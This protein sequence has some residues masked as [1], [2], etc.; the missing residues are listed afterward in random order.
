MDVERNSKTRCVGDEFGCRKHDL[1]VDDIRT[2]NQN[3]GNRDNGNKRNMGLD[4]GKVPEFVVG[5]SD[6]RVFIHRQGE[7]ITTTSSTHKNGSGNDKKNRVVNGCGI[8]HVDF[9]ESNSVDNEN[10]NG[11]DV[12]ND[13]DFAS[14]V[15]IQHS[16]T[17]R[18]PVSLKV[19][20]SDDSDHQ[21]AS[22]FDPAK[23]LFSNSSTLV[24]K[25]N[26]SISPAYKNGSGKCSSSIENA[27]KT[28]EQG[29]QRNDT[30][31]VSLIHQD[32]IDRSQ[33]EPLPTSGSINLVQ[34]MSDGLF[35]HFGNIK[36]QTDRLI[37]EYSDFVRSNKQCQ[38][39]YNAILD[40]EHE[41]S[42]RLDCVEPKVEGASDMILSSGIVSSGTSFSLTNLGGSY[43]KQLQQQ[44]LHQNKYHDEGVADDDSRHC[45]LVLPPTDVQ[46]R[47]SFGPSTSTTDHHL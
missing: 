13:A 38:K 44:D 29:R 43:F 7:S 36:S 5:A 27:D 11:S 10:K 45:S 40:L 6:G 47:R 32:Q 42:K 23:N 41:E 25:D 14:I 19:N 24:N 16:L 20:I 8:D 30:F 2:N 18:A 1:K 12:C 28:G 26:K 17:S 22:C 15:A 9:F 31:C 21:I 46:Q 39:N 37:Q 4:A 3:S 34:T 35:K 33:E